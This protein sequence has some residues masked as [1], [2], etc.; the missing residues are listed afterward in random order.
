V[1]PLRFRGGEEILKPSW[2][3]GMIFRGTAKPREERRGIGLCDLR[4]G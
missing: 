2:S 4:G 1:R 3:A